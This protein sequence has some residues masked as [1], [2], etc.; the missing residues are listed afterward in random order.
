M[1]ENVVFVV[2]YIDVDCGLSTSA[3]PSVTG[4]LDTP[5]CCS[6]QCED[7]ED[8]GCIPRGDRCTYVGLQTANATYNATCRFQ[9]NTVRPAVMSST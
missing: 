6:M 7:E 5:A 4:I 2:G 1:G 9:V 8:D 3:L